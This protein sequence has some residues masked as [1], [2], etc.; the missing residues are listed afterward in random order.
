V[1]AAI[2]A[3]PD[4]LEDELLLE[5]ELELELERDDDEE[6]ELLLELDEELEDEL[7]EG[8]GDELDDDGLDDGEP[9]DEL[10]DPSGPVGVPSE[11]AC[12]SIPRPATATLPDRIRRNWR[13]SSRRSF[14]PGTEGV[15]DML[16]T[17]ASTMSNWRARGGGRLTT[18]GAR[19][20]RS[21]VRWR[22][23][24]LLT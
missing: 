17:S 8:L 15:L 20:P 12:P 5:L 1:G 16:Q 11:H 21:S 2:R 24:R 10:E 14:P 4:E 7:D 13:R 22:G 23:S 3:E 18:A 6:D 9:E 19:R